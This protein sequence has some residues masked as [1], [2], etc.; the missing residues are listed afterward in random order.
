MKREHYPPRFV[1]SLRRHSYVVFVLGYL[2][3]LAAFS[4]HAHS[5]WNRS[6]AFFLPLM[7][8][9]GC[10]G[11]VR[12]WTRPWLALVMIGLSFQVISGPIDSLGN[13]GGALSLF[14]LDERV[15]GFNLTGWAQDKFLSAPITA[16]ASLAYAALLPFVLG[17]A[18]A[19]WRYRRGNF[20][21]FVTSIV[22]TSYG[23]L[24][25]FVLM[26]TAP[27]WFS[28]VA[29]NLFQ[30]SGLETTINFLAPL[31]SLV[32]PNYFAAFPSLHSAY[33]IT[34]CYFLSKVNYK[35]G[36]FGALMT[37]A[38]LFSTLYLGQHYA[39]DL[40]GGAVYSLVPCLALNLKGLRR[41]GGRGKGSGLPAPRVKIQSA[42]VTKRATESEN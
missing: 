31:S 16:G 40:I 7:A 26:P 24:L 22:L 37:V 32:V 3:T 4:M 14:D 42:R 18:F 34:C 13:S 41:G 23:A 17:T 36:L 35:L 38:T 2:A 27:P 21:M 30:S 15:W 9:V 20:A 5:F 29:I 8:L 12:P 28:G 39:I 11:M 19:I 33:T 6:T 10:L 25:T 1:E